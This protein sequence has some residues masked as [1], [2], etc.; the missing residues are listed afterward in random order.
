M[1]GAIKRSFRTKNPGGLTYAV[2]SPSP[3]PIQFDHYSTA[4]K[5]HYEVY[6]FSPGPRQCAVL[7]TN[8]SDRRLAEEIA[9]S[10]K[11]KAEEALSLLNAALESTAEG[12]YVVDKERKIT[13]YNQNLVQIWNIGELL[14]KTRDDDTVLEFLQGQVRDPGVSLP[15]SVTSTTMPAGRGP[16]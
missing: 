8:V 6:A 11:R 16:R 2:L 15:V 12:I 10:A 13:S 3:A 7:F 4:L 14:Q 1:E 9:V 5:N